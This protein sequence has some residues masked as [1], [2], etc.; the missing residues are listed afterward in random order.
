MD[1][2]MKEK[3]QKHSPTI[4]IITEKLFD[5]ILKMFGVL[6]FIHLLLTI[7]FEFQFI[8][9]VADI[10][11]ILVFVFIKFL[12][13]K[14]YKIQFI[15]WAFAFLS[16]LILFFYFVLFN[17]SNGPQGILALTSIFLLVTIDPKNRFFPFFILATLS[18]LFCL[19][20]EYNYSSF[21]YSFPN[22]GYELFNMGFITVTVGAIVTFTIKYTQ[23]RYLEQKV[24]V[25]QKNTALIETKSKIEL[26]K[27][28][29]T[30]LTELQTNFLLEQDLGAS[31]N[32]ILNCILKENNSTYGLI[33]II[34]EKE[35]DYS[36]IAMSHRAWTDVLTKL[37]H[38][39]A[40]DWIKLNK[41][42]VLLEKCLQNKRLVS[43]EFKVIIN[44]TQKGNQFYSFV[45]VI[46][47]QEFI[48][49][50]FLVRPEIRYK[51]IETGL[52][53]LFNSVFATI[54]QHNKLKEKQR[55][56]EHQLKLSKK[57][58][59]DNLQMKTQFL[60][61]I[62]HE[63]RTP[64]SL[65]IGPVSSLLS[66]EEGSLSFA[67]VK[68]SLSLS[69]DNSHKISLFLEDIANLSRLSSNQLSIHRTTYNFYTFIFQLFNRFKIQTL[70][71]TIDFSLIYEMD[72]SIDIYF[73]LRKIENIVSNLLSNAFKFTANN[74]KVQLSVKDE[75]KSILIE[76][77]DNGV[78]IDLVDIDNIFDR[79]YQTNNKEK[80]IFSGTG[81]GLALSQELAQLLGFEINV[82]S[83][84][85]VGS[86]FYFRMPKTISTE[87]SKEFKNNYKQKEITS[88]LSL[89]NSD[90]TFCIL[91][92]EDN[93]DMRLF[94][95]E[96]L[97]SIYNI[98]TAQNGQQALDILRTDK[99]NIDLIITD[100]MMPKLDGFTFIKHLNENSDTAKIP[101][102][103]LTAMQED[104][105]K[106]EALELGVNDFLT[107]PFV[108]QELLIK[109][110]NILSDTNIKKM[111]AEDQK[112]RKEEVPVAEDN[113]LA[114]KMQII[115]DLVLE[116]IDNI[117]FNI[118]SL[119]V[120]LNMS[121][122][123][124]Y[125]FVQDNVGLTPLKLVRDIK[126][127]IANSYLHEG[128]FDN[129]KELVHA[130]GF[131]TVRHF[132]K[133]YSE[134]FQKDPIDFFE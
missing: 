84:P 23:V 60:T 33:S 75:E 123:N 58:A 1:K 108:V 76:V 88:N 25:E 51:K 133:S 72:K 115:K 48:G 117:E 31:Y 73:D 134:R 122:R 68:N 34:N 96:T 49:F 85:N 119:A 103:V 107:K 56:F 20:V 29:L 36:V 97:C 78:G 2:K 80:T 95:Q 101:I 52:I 81:V 128:S 83:A 14:N 17:G 16:Q 26:R 98:K 93:Y 129:L 99:Q 130:S 45:P 4:N 102:L 69:L 28:Y 65:I 70:Y 94:I 40:H 120:Q 89:E 7:I 105:I 30:S 3:I 100:L 53:E 8:Y 74:G 9:V 18:T 92:V 57:S 77:I 106:V 6:V 111:W 132:R 90:N 59:E 112:L 43:D 124:L 114:D 37:Y 54:I 67:K 71:R 131:N 46:R 24:A 121:K 32:N 64:L 91:I 38:Q 127:D 86:R 63:L 5:V 62:S 27:E 113:Q 41:L 87:V 12:F 79:F 118:D 15:N 44:D 126:L 61:N 109:L 39:N 10:S 125:R 11:V 35:T 42:N 116:N 21:L 13:R 66:N 50:V 55:V 22:K 104:S 82:S 47:N 110:K 19:W